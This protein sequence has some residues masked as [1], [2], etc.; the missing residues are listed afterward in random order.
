MYYIYLIFEKLNDEYKNNIKYYFKNF[1]FKIIL[2]NQLENIRKNNS[3][4]MD[5]ILFK[6]NYYPF[7]DFENKLNDIFKEN[8]ITYLCKDN[9]I[10]F[11]PDDNWK[12]NN[13]SLEITGNKTINN[14]I[15]DTTNIYNNIKHLE[16]KKISENYNM[17]YNIY[18]NIGNFKYYNIYNKNLSLKSIHD[19]LNTEN[20]KDKFYLV[21]IFLS[22]DNINLLEDINKITYKQCRFIIVLNHI[23]YNLD[24]VINAKINYLKKKYDIY[25]IK[26][27]NFLYLLINNIGLVFENLLFVNSNYIPELYS[28]NN[29]KHQIIS[30]K[31]YLLI[32]LNI[33][34]KNPF[35]NSKYYK[36]RNLKDFY[37]RIDWFLL[38]NHNNLYTNNIIKYNPKLKIPLKYSILEKLLLEIKD[39]E[40]LLDLIS[41]E[42]EIN[43][44]PL[45]ANE[46]A[47]KRI[48]V[49]ILTEKESILES[50]VIN[51]LPKFDDVQLLETLAMLIEKTKFDEIKKIM[52]TK[53]LGKT[54]ITDDKSCHKSIIVLNKAISYS[55]NKDSFISVCDYILNHEK[56]IEMIKNNNKLK[57]HVIFKLLNLSLNH[58]SE[59][60]IIDKLSIIF[61]KIYDIDNLTD[62]NNLLKFNFP[63]P[64]NIIFTNFIISNAIKFNQYY[65]SY[66]DF[67]KNRDRIKNNLNNILE[68]TKDLK[69]NLDLKF[70]LFFK[71]GNFELSYQGVPS[72]DIFMLKNKLIRQLCPSLNYKIDTNYKNDKIK[73]L[74]H[75][76]FLNRQ[77]S[78]YKDRH[79]VIKGM[80]EDSRFDV[81]F[82]TF[83]KLDNSVKFTFGKAKH[84]KLPKDLN[85]IKNI[86][87]GYKFDIIVYCEIGM[88]QIAYL[89]ACMKLAK[90]QCNTWGHSDTSGIDTV[91][92][93]F[94]SKLYELPYEESQ[95]HYSEKLVLQNSLCTSYVN[96]LSRHNPSLFKSKEHFGI[97]NDTVAIFCAQSLFKLNPIYDDY[98]IQI[99]KGID[100]CI[101]VLLENE[102][103]SKVIKR[104]NNTGVGYKLRFFPGMQHFD[105]MN[106]MNICDFVLDVY[107]FGGCNSSFES[108]SLGK[109]IVTQ[110]SLMI[111]GRFTTGFYKKMGLDEYICNT[112]EEY[113]NFAIKLGNDNE[114]RKEIETK[115]KENNS[116]LF[117][118]KETVDEW[119][120]DLFTFYNE[121]E[122]SKN[123]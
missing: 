23:D 98:L 123:N 93:Y 76:S 111:N 35:L 113:I 92:Y 31:D 28:F 60:V 97:T 64:Y 84:I 105:Y 7:N 83:E 6:S 55:L 114:Y 41:N 94:S 115:I 54:E 116:K 56:M 107:P 25:F 69:V 109:V 15:F 14:Y 48:T 29:N 21:V 73:V 43:T 71:I 82:S 112:K 20:I 119:K 10:L 38:D 85:E 19:F 77:H 37:N 90:I 118:D 30:N 12:F 50:N 24:I 40:T 68:L 33:F 70:V 5:I 80:S 104:F 101:L 87:S 58:I 74:F 61:N 91:D 62:F 57:E 65:E 52:W 89:M 44:D 78:V 75:A 1:Q 22:K 95:T 42:I 63:I 121:Y 79:Q 102:S 8:N 2:I 11:I 81:Y 18:N 51:M 67:I 106:L 13:H 108:F 103:K 100:N 39:Y 122:N 120:E 32:P 34:I 27:I 86:L 4:K 66:D 110:P 96:P 3:N 88:D 45:K 16:Y 47:I 117:L 99:L 59:D 72:A 17:L 53:I 9:N 46:L 49:A 26:S 36:I